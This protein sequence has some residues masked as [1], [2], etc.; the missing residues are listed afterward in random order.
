MI[1]HRVGVC[2]WN[3]YWLVALALLV[4]AGP[5]ICFRAAKSC[6]GGGGNLRQQKNASTGMKGF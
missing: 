6:C 4:V 5:V 1:Q 2:E 3:V